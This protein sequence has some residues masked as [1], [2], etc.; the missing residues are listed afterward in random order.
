[1]RYGEAKCTWGV[2]TLQRALQFA[3][4]RVPWVNAAISGALRGRG[5]QGIVVGWGER[6]FIVVSAARSRKGRLL[7]ESSGKTLLP[8]RGVWSL[9][10]ELRTHMTCGAA[11]NKE[12]PPHPHPPEK[13]E[14]GKAG[15]ADLGRDGLNHFS[16]L[17]GLENSMD[18]GTWW[19]SVHRVAKSQTR[20][21]D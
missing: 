9:V 21:N 20:L 18:R 6:I 5:S 3:V 15:L 16:W 17:W 7:W 13:K 4:L 19:T 1:M 14:A 11:K 10:V 8:L 12:P 2:G